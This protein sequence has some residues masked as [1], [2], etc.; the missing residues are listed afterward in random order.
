MNW[1]S[2]GCL[3]SAY[4]ACQSPLLYCPAPA[5]T[6]GGSVEGRSAGWYPLGSNLKVNCQQG[7]RPLGENVLRCIGGSWRNNGV[8]CQPWDCGE[9]EETG[10]KV[11]LLDNGT[12]FGSRATVS[13]SDGFFGV[14]E[15][16][17]TLTCGSDGWTGEQVKCVELQCQQPIEIE[18]ATVSMNYENGLFFANYSC[19][20]TSKNI[21]LKCLN[22]KWKGNDANCKQNTLKEN[23]KYEIVENDVEIRINGLD[24]KEEDIDIKIEESII[25]EEEI[26]NVDVGE[27]EEERSNEKGRIVNI[28]FNQI[29]DEEKIADLRIL[30]TPK[31]NSGNSGTQSV[32]ITRVSV[33]LMLL[34]N[35]FL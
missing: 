25:G 10:F 27:V 9:I 35:L 21:S 18:E 15:N 30:S 1:N 11:E 13:C 4:T 17:S 5:V 3:I 19:I 31:P 12:D 23:M 24:I 8:G 29:E 2:I 14:S 26:N 33:S 7:Y 16:V 20:K 34:G 32:L 6:E 28:P 22:G